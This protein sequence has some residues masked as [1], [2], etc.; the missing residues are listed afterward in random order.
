[1]YQVLF[2]QIDQVLF[3]F[4]YL[5]CPHTYSFISVVSSHGI[6]RTWRLCWVTWKLAMFTWCMLREIGCKS[7]DIDIDVQISGRLKAW[8]WHWQLLG[9]LKLRRLLAC[10][11]PHRRSS[12][13]TIRVDGSDRPSVYGGLKK[14]AMWVQEAY[15]QAKNVP[16]YFQINPCTAGG[17]LG[18]HSNITLCK[19]KIEYVIWA[20][21]PALG[22][23]RSFSADKKKRE[24]RNKIEA[25]ESIQ[26]N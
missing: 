8:T 22:P 2:R 25:E 18:Y 1:M 11:W 9:R 7:D 26:Q 6:E 14:L 16:F 19:N 15:S 5:C 10:G 13:H 23:V 3:W 17:I 21:G 4:W 20:E 12:S 24:K